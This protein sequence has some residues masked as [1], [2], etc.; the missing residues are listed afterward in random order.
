M[1]IWLPPRRISLNRPKTHIHAKFQLFIQQHEPRPEH[2]GKKTHKKSFSSPGYDGKVKFKKHINAFTHA[3][4]EYNRKK[5]EIQKSKE[6]IKNKKQETKLALQRYKNAKACKMK[7]MSRKTKK[8]QP[9]MKYRM[10][11]LLERI[12]NGIIQ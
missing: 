4:E 12:Q 6:E 3:V 9:V 8:G 2:K 7:K 11:N 10:Q 5:L 1:K